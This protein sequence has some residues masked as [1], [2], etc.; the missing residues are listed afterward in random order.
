MT[1]NTVLVL[2][3]GLVGGF[4]LGY[5]TAWRLA[6]KLEHFGVSAYGWDTVDW[7]STPEK[8]RQFPASLGRG[9]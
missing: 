7:Q 8:P 9:V 5:L 1:A 4:C 2:L 6:R 3:A